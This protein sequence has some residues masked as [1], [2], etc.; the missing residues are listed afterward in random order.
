MYSRPHSLGVDA[1]PR[2]LR[3]RGWCLGWGSVCAEVFSSP[4][5]PSWEQ[6]ME[7]AAGGPTASVPDPSRTARD[8]WRE[9]LQSLAPLR[10]ARD[11]WMRSC[12]SESCMGS[13]AGTMK[14]PPRCQERLAYQVRRCRGALRKPAPSSS[15]NCRN[16]TSARWT[17]SPCFSMGRPS[18]T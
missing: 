18:Q 15:R 5:P 3:G 11:S 14:P 6:A 12:S 10:G 4:W 9:L 2:T 17:L 8:G 13:P 16:A 7:C 1:Y